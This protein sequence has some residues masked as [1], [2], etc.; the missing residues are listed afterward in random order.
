[1]RSLNVSIK[2]GT[3]YN[4]QSNHVERFYKTLLKAKKANGVN[5]WEKS[6]LTFNFSTQDYS[7]LCSPRIKLI[8]RK[9]DKT[10]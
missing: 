7:T 1:M 2:V 9:G 8:F 5:D 4:H 6:L 10:A 3:P